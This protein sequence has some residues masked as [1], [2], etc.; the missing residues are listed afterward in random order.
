MDCPT[1]SGRDK[2][3]TTARVDA[4]FAK[5]AHRIRRAFACTRA[6]VDRDAPV[7]PCAAIDRRHAHD[8]PPHPGAASRQANTWSP[9]PASA[10]SRVRV[11]APTPAAVSGRRP[12]IHAEELALPAGFCS[13][14]R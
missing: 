5:A 2:A 6:A 10:S 14:G 4:L 13:A 12:R 1:I 9:R 7:S 8:L 11:V 3:S